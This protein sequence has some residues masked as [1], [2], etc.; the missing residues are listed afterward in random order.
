[1]LCPDRARVVRIGGVAGHDHPVRAERVRRADQ[2]ADVAGSRGPVEDDREQVG[3]L[4]DPVQPVLR[5]GDDGDQLLLVLA[6]ELAHQFGRKQN[7]IVLLQ[8]LA[9]PAGLRPVGVQQGPDLQ[10][11]ST[12]S[13]IGRTPWTRNSPARCRFVQLVSSACHCWNAALRVLIRRTTPFCRCW[14][15]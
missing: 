13:V 15:A 10:P 9:R 5:E 7:V 4:R 11:C 14:R 2:R 8:E 3:R 6:T 1:V 12:A